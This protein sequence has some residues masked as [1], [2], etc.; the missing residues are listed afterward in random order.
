MMTVE[1]HLQGLN[2][3]QKAALHIKGPL[4]IV[5]G[6][7][8]EKPN[9]HPSDCESDKKWNSAGKNF[10]RHFHQQ[11]RQRDENGSLQK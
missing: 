11:S 5:A 1:N 6:A 9:H 2:K 3:E 8:A 7:G 4:L 10:G